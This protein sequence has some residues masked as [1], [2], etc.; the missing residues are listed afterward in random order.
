MNRCSKLK[1]YIKANEHQEDEY[2]CEKM[3]QHMKSDNFDL[4]YDKQMAETYLVSRGGYIIYW[5]FDFC[6]FCGTEIK[7]KWEHYNITIENELGI[8]MK[9]FL[10][11]MEKLYELIPEE[12][13][14]DEWWKKRGL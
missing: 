2:C 6:P 5:R 1:G 7:N 12:F 9:D 13:Q 3:K 11:N 8:D 4:Y 10:Y 14:T